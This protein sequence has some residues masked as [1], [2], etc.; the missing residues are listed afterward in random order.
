MLS[1]VDLFCGGGFG[2]RVLYA[3]VDDRYSVSMPGNWPLIPINPISLKANVLQQPIEELEPL[4]V[5]E[6]VQAR[7]SF[8]LS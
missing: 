3:P 5:V 2:A 7:R 8:D 4:R 1:F 6:K